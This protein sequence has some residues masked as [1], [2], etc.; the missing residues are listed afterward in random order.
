MFLDLA[1]R[2]RSIRRYLPRPVETEKRDLLVEAALRAPSSM[3]RTPWEFVVVSDPALLAAL[4][5][6]KP[7]GASFLEHAPLGI[8]VCADPTKGGVWVEDAA[9][10][11]TFLHL[12]AT[13]LGL[14]SCW[15]QIRGREHDG[16]RTSSQYVAEVVGLPE[17]REVEAIVAVGYPGEERPP[18]PREAL[19][20]ERVFYETYGRTLPPE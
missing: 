10:A 9:I 20:F 19:P 2:R 6:A 18:H 5:R 1:R 7:H 8:V 16:Q 15:I 4:S 11:A 3:G 14:G 13:S 17:D 12:A